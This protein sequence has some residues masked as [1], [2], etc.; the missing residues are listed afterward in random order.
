MVPPPQLQTWVPWSEAAGVARV[1]VE[2]FRDLLRKYRRSSLLIACSR[3]SVLFNFGLEGD[4]TAGDD[5]TAQWIPA[6]FS[7]KIAQRVMLLAQHGRLI[8]FQA[9]LRYLARE[10][11]RLGTSDDDFPPVHD[12]AAGQ[13]LLMAGELL[14]R[15][16]VTLDDPLDE[17]ANKIATFLPFYEIDSVNAPTMQFLRFY[18]LLSVIIPRLPE[19]LRLYDVAALFEEQFGFPLKEY[20]E[21]IFCFFMHATTQRDK[22]SLEAA[23]D[24]AIGIGTFRYT[25]VSPEALSRMFDTVCFTLDT[26]VEGKEPIGFA[27]F[28]L[29]RDRPYLR[30]QEELFCL[31]YEFAANKM[32][33]GVL[34][35]VLRKLKSEADK[36]NYLSFWGYVFEYY[37]AW[38]FEE[39]A[40]TAENRFYP[41]P[42]YTDDPSKQ[43]CD[44]IIV[45]GSTGVL[46][47]AKLATCPSDVRYSGDYRKM[48]MFMEERLVVG[49]KGPVG[50][51]QLLNAI[52]NITRLPPSALPFWIRH[53]R[54]FIPLILTKDDIGSSWVVNSYLNAR[55]Q[56][57]RKRA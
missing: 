42:T 19:H 43:I 46:V 48:R 23:V 56:E 45:C 28:D 26:P 12:G 13:L 50:V 47:E 10:V 24:S 25:S 51:G 2:E 31:D 11:I 22:K 49:K 5:I 54:K 7:P 33:S 15:K 4:I 44:A 41:S 53:I 16:Y 9:Q 52:E 20:C 3:L 18:T 38:L 1:T 40:S 35:R 14:Y 30:Y 55:F 8:F 6:F 21:F 32:E 57:A 29:L 27:D 36:T 39:Y 37:V 17:M 34:W